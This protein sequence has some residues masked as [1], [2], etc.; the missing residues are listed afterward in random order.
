MINSQEAKAEEATKL[1]AIATDLGTTK[2]EREAAAAAICRLFEKEKDVVRKPTDAYGMTP[3]PSKG[4]KLGDTVR[5]IFGKDGVCTS[6]EYESESHKERFMVD[7]SFPD[8]TPSH[9]MFSTMYIEHRKPSADEMALREALSQTVCQPLSYTI[10]CK[11]S[12]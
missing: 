12:V 2:K 8:A 9:A 3:A 10:E 5:H 7:A 4:F 6:D 11:G 1:I